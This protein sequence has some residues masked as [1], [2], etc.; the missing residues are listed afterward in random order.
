MTKTKSSRRIA[1]VEC[2]VMSD[3]EQNKASLEKYVAER[4]REKRAE[5]QTDSRVAKYIWRYFICG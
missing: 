2:K 3:E 4:K 1:Q 5:R